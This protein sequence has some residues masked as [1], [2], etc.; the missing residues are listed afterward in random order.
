AQLPEPGTKHN[1]QST[2]HNEQSTKH[3]EQST[4]HDKRRTKH[5]APHG[6]LEW[7]LGNRGG[8]VKGFANAIYTGFTT[9]EMARIID[10]VLVQHPELHGVWQVSSEP[11]SKYELLNMVNE[12]LKLGIVID[13][14][15]EFHCDRSLDSTRFR[16]T[17]GYQPP[18]WDDM[19]AELH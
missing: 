17:T 10:L 6:L 16:E 18:T 15:D 13:R 11:I 9:H 8:R 2:K 14:D 1:E 12:Q 3:N 7:F 19:I 4:K 5:N